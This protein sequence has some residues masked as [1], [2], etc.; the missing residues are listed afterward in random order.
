MNMNLISHFMKG[1]T[2]MSFKLKKA[3]IFPLLNCVSVY[4]LSMPS[5]MKVLKVKPSIM[6]KK[7]GV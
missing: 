5:P 7:S 4:N 6:L 3:C 2:K 1:G